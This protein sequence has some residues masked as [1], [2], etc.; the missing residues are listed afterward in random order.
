VF[1]LQGARFRGG[2]PPTQGVGGGG[3]QQV[4]GAL[5]PRWPGSGNVTKLRQ[6]NPGGIEEQ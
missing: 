1:G 4:G 5:V 2:L 3:D 6:N